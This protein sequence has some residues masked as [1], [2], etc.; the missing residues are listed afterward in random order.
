MVLY[1]ND[2]CS[3]NS[4]Y[5]RVV[6]KESKSSKSDGVPIVMTR[7]QISLLLSVFLDLLFAPPVL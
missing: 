2:F 5:F 3:L 6:F 7:L 4:Q 1:C